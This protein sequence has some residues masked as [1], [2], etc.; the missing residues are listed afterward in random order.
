MS[1]FFLHL[2]WY[3]LGGASAWYILRKAVQSREKKLI[4]ME[5]KLNILVN[6]F[7]VLQNRIRNH[8]H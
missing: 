1:E 8:K 5:K 7:I 3:C 2:M 6:E 4:F